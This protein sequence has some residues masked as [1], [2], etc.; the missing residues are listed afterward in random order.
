MPPARPDGLEP[1]ESAGLGAGRDARRRVRLTLCGPVWQAKRTSELAVKLAAMDELRTKIRG[2]PDRRCREVPLVETYV[3][4]ASY[5]VMW[6]YGAFEAR[7]PAIVEA[8]RATDADVICLQ[9][10]YEELSGSRRNLAALLASALSSGGRSLRR[11]RGAACGAPVRHKL[12]L[13]TPCCTC[14]LC[15]I[16]I[17]CKRVTP[18]CRVLAARDGECPDSKMHYCFDAISEIEGQ[19]A[20][21]VRFG[22]AVL[23]RWPIAKSVSTPLPAAP[24]RLADLEGPRLVPRPLPPR[25]VLRFLSRRPSCRPLLPLCLDCLALLPTHRLHLQWGAPLVLCRAAQVLSC[26][27]DG[28]RGPLAVHCTQVRPSFSP[29]LHQDCRLSLC[30]GTAAAAAQAS[31]RSCV[32][33]VTCSR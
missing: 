32:H 5:N 10:A 26:V 19:D 1:L 17:A 14:A 6:Q 28:P 21:A 12:C 9:E 4:V 30:A 27:I 24:A 29:F 25:L 11:V 3:R 23:S 8:L 31:G 22:N 33:A 13:P 16:G 15:S 20:S 18:S 7:F 2:Y